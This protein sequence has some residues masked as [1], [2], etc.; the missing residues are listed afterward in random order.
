M[1]IMWGTIAVISALAI[2]A[3]I[4]YVIQDELRANRRRQALKRLEDASL[5]SNGTYARFDQEQMLRN[6]SERSQDW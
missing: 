2:V 6:R 3:G 1:Q 5:S 4:V